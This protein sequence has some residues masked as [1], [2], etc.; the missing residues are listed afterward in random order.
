MLIAIQKGVIV[1][2]SSIQENVISLIYSSGKIA[3]ICR[4]EGQYLLS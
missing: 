1:R 4:Q 3:E 2:C